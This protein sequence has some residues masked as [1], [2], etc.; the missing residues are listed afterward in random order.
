MRNSALA[1]LVLGALTMIGNTPAKAYGSRHAF[2]LQGDESPGLS[3]CTYDS[4]AQ[5]LASASGRPLYCIANPYFTGASDDPY[6]YSNRN[7][8]FPPR[9]I[10][11]PPNA[12]W[13]R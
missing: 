1:V 6:A 13:M 3:A 12:N 9:Y 7:R 11:Y 10:P 2:C 4:Y 8:P 5:C